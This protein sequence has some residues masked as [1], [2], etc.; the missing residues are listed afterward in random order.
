M[1]ILTLY[2]QQHFRKATCEASRFSRL[3]LSTRAKDSNKESTSTL[4]ESSFCPPVALAKSS[5]DWMMNLK[6]YSRERK[7]LMIGSCFSVWGQ[8]SDKCLTQLMRPL[9]HWQNKDNH[10]KYKQLISSVKL[11]RNSTKHKQHLQNRQTTT[12]LWW[13]YYILEINQTSFINTYL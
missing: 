11:H 8:R 2:T 13:P 6:I 3:M 7:H 12:I 9:K 10:F 1:Q 4:K 5:L